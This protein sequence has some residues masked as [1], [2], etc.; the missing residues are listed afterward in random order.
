MRRQ[1]IWPDCNRPK[2]TELEFFL[3]SFQ[4]GFFFF[5]LWIKIIIQMDKSCS[6]EPYGGVKNIYKPANPYLI[7]DIASSCGSKKKK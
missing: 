1:S 7:L 6:M 5:A 3:F 4:I 2:K